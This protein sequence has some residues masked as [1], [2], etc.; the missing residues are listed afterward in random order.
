MKRTAC[1]LLLAATAWGQQVAVPQG[2]TLGPSCNLS[3]AATLSADKLDGSH[4]AVNPGANAVPVADSNGKIAPGWIPLPTASS[5][6]GIFMD[7]DCLAGSHVNGIDTATGRLKCFADSGG[8]W[9]TIVN[10]PANFPPDTNASAWLDLLATIALKAPKDNPSF[11][12]TATASDIVVTS[13]LQVG[14]GA[15]LLEHL[16]GTDAPT[17]ACTAGTYERQV[18]ANDTEIYT[19]KNGAWVETSAGAE[20]SE[21]S[22]KPSVFPPD[23]ADGALTA[24]LAGKAAVHDAVLTGTTTTE[25]EQVQTSLQVGSGSPLVNLTYGSDAPVGSCTAGM[26][27][28]Q[29]GAYDTRT[30]ICQGGGWV[31][32]T[33]GAASGVAQLDGSGK[34]P[35]TQLPA[36][37]VWSPTI[38]RD[39]SAS[40]GLNYARW[41]PSRGITVTRI[42]IDLQG[43]SAS[44][45]S[46]TMPRLRVSNGTSSRIISLSNGVGG[47]DTGAISENFAANLTMQV[48][49]LQ[50]SSCTTYPSTPAVAVSY[51]MQ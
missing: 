6:G 16:Y 47:Y 22:N 21:I 45:C 43:A 46:G 44:G 33:P 20:W 29:N 42:E 49:L 34:L 5:I 30:Y 31:E 18:A 3:D 48:D 24:A 8:D 12:G 1:M 27:A 9:N 13:S 26:Y 11:T 28:Q 35:G 17:G 38:H 10:K 39:W 7:A 14:T 23:M 15:P 50:G 32:S 51:T 2:G 36:V 41:T 25:Q 37:M 4:G 19:C 40:D